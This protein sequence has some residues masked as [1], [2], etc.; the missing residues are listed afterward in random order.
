MIA[1][2]VIA[3]RSETARRFARRLGRSRK[4]VEVGHRSIDDL[5]PLVGTSIDPSPV[6]G[7][8]GRW[9]APRSAAREEQG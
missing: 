4:I 8:D 9:G 2:A 3:N 6:A 7:E 5:P 1:P